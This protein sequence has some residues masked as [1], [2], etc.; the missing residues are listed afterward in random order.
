MWRDVSR[1][2]FVF[3]FGSFIIV[4]SSYAK[5]INLRLEINLNRIV[6]FLSII[7]N[8]ICCFRRT[9][10]F[11]SLFLQYYFSDVLYKSCLSRCYLPI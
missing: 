5:D 4:S 10:D 2:A 3:G 11:L 9:E 1:S 6:I 8:I 7:Y